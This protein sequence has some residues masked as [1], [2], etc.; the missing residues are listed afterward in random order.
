[1]NLII[2]IILII[3]IGVLSS[4][5]FR[6]IVG[7]FYDNIFKW[8]VYLLCIVGIVAI[9]ATCIYWIFMLMH[10][11]DIKHGGHFWG[12]VVCYIIITVIA[13]P[14]LCIREKIK[15]RKTRRQSEV[16]K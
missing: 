11:Y 1:M 2:A 12:Y 4:E 6:T 16:K 10:D 13:V 3:L 7:I 15:N 14:I 8:L 5:R 9:V